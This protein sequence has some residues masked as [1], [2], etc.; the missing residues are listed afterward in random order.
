MSRFRYLGNREHILLG[1]PIRVMSPGEVI[2]AA[3]NPDPTMFQVLSED[4]SS[5]PDQSFANKAA[6]CGAPADSPED[7]E[8]GPGGERR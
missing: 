7:H 2:D 8:A 4:A 5:P 1:P 3:T 6:S